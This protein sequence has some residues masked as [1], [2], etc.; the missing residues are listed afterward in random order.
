VLRATTLLSCDACEAAA[1]CCERGWRAYLTVGPRDD[2]DVV[3]VCPDCAER[4]M[5]DD[6]TPWSG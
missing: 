2:T 1:D 4:L 6:E 5:G 3:V